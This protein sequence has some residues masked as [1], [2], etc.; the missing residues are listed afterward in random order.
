MKYFVLLILIFIFLNSCNWLPESQV[1][2]ISGKNAISREKVIEKFN[3]ATI[4]LFESCPNHTDAFNY[5]INYGFANQFNSVYYRNEQVE[6]CLLFYLT[7][8]CSKYQD[9]SSQIQNI[10]N[11]IYLCKL[12]EISVK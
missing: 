5:M 6:I 3:I 4:S 7:N 12:K 2:Q 11:I 1:S 8:A 10:K 9:I